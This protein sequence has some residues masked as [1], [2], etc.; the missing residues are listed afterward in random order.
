MDLVDCLE[1]VVIIL[2]L[3]W[4]SIWLFM[5]WFWIFVLILYCDSLVVIRGCLL[6]F[7]LLFALVV[8][9]CVWFA[10]GLWFNSVV[11]LFAL[12]AFAGRFCVFFV[13]F[14]FELGV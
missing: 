10:C 13:G 11:Y 14:G 1:F 9:A 8:C 5:C 3:F 4:E 2:R 6:C 12:Y 7:E